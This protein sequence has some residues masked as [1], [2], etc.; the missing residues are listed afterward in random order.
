MKRLALAAGLG[1]L[2]LNAG[3]QTCPRP[4]L[5]KYTVHTPIKRSSRAFT[6]GLEFRDGYLWESVGS[7]ANNQD[8]GNPTKLQRIGLDGNVQLVRQLPGKVFGEGLTFVG[9]RIFQG[10]WTEKVM[11]VHSPGA[12]APLQS[13]GFGFEVWGLSY[14]GQSILHT[15]G[16]A[17]LRFI[18][19]ATLQEQRN[20]TIK[21]GHRPL[22][23]VNELEW[24]EGKL[25]GNVWQNDRIVRI[26]TQTGCVD[27]EMD[28]SLLREYMDSSEKAYLAQDP[29]NVLNGI[30]YDPSS[31]FIYLTGKNWGYIY[32][33]QVNP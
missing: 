11:F 3:A 14:D 10:T 23:E 6:Q 18:D 24:I 13:V 25:Y 31:K 19:P 4:Q 8:Y 28:G 30:A 17:I 7:F 20:V 1:L 32:P 2:A 33:V 9:N 21:D 15:D 12:D 29:N 5:I 27:G 22:A 26:N 16:S